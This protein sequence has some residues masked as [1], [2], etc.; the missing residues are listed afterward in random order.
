M[1]F[2]KN[3]FVD[4]EFTNYEREF[5][6]KEFANMDSELT[7]DY[8]SDFPSVKWNSQL[9]NSQPRIIFNSR[10][11]SEFPSAKMNSQP[12]IIFY[13]RILSEFRS[14]EFQGRS[15]KKGGGITAAPL[16]ND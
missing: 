1:E 8:L 4:L 5:H 11:L 2:A 6:G 12:R 9:T 14:A 10:I 16:N 7:K 15:N 3:D 13:S